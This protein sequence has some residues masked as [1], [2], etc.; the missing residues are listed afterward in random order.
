[1]LR[2]SMLVLLKFCSKFCQAIFLL[3]WDLLPTHACSVSLIVRI[4]IQ[5]FRFTGVFSIAQLYADT[6]SVQSWMCGFF[7]FFFALFFFF[8]AGSNSFFT[9]A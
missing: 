9:T 6:F 3:P 2:R 8:N 4:Q 7:F 5:D 1:M